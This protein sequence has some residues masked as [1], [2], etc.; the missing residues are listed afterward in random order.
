[1]LESFPESLFDDMLQ[2]TLETGLPFAD[3]SGVEPKSG[4]EFFTSDHKGP[5]PT[6]FPTCE[7]F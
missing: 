6:G 7:E 3:I 5:L 4:N 2:Q 1:M